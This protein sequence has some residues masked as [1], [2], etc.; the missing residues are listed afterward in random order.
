M[1]I[2]KSQLVNNPENLR[3]HVVILGAGA[4]VAAFPNGD[5]N[6]KRLPMMDNFVEMLGLEPLLERA[7]VKNIY[8][9]FEEVYSELYENDP[10][11]PLLKEIEE[12]VYA[13]FERLR[14]PE[15]PTLYD[16]LLMSL[17]PK[18]IVATFNWDPFLFD[19][20]ER[21]RYKIPLPHIA[22]LH[23]N[24]R[25][26]YCLEHRVQ[27]EKGRYCPECDRQLTP[28]RLLYPITKKN[29]SDNPFIENEWELLKID[30]E[31][32]MTLTIFGYSVP[33][34]DKDAVDMME[35]AWNRDNRFI[36]RT[37]IIDIKNKADLRQQWSP[38]IVETYFDHCQHYYESRISE[39]ARRSCEALFCQTF[40][41][42]RVES[43]PIPRDADFNGLI[44]WLEPLVKA[45]RALD[46]T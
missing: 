14:L 18:D 1:R 46:S 45:E 7:G 35:S 28:S 3:G 23:G 30:L 9:N 10:E 32:A 19:A 17:R 5:A 33:N 44:S 13:Y 38:F 26:G 12:T 8:R 27:G 42:R 25:I 6:G 15:L 20:W 24:V 34:T 2:A 31:K 21:N 40:Y 22:H 11:S 37:E 41:G 29:Y 36:E 43:N 16:H 39:Y 4:S